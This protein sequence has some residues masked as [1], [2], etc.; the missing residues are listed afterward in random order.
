MPYTYI[1][2]FYVNN[3]DMGILKIQ[4][5]GPHGT[6]FLRNETRSTVDPRTTWLGTVWVHL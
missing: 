5:Y 6:Y 4:V 1:L 2:Y 3:T